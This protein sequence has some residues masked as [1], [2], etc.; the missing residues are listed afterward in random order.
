MFDRQENESAES[1]LC[2]REYKSRKMH[3]IC[4]NQL[5]INQQ[6]LEQNSPLNQV[7]GSTDQRTSLSLTALLSSEAEAGVA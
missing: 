5:D 4:I 7:I 3:C 1:T 2:L 6:T